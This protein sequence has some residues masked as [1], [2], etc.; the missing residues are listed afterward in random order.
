MYLASAIGPRSAWPELSP[1]MAR[2]RGGV[3]RPTQVYLVCSARARVGKTLLARLIVEYCRADAQP[4]T[5]YTIDPI[6]VALNDFL[7][8]VATTISLTETREQ[9]KLFDRLVIDDATTKIVDIGHQ[10]VDK[11]FTI[12]YDI[13][14]AAE[15][16]G[17]GIDVLVAYLADPSDLSQ[18]TYMALRARFPE[19]S[20]VPVF[21]DAIARGLDFRNMFPASSG[22]IHALTIPQMSPGVHVIADQHPFSF[23]DFLRRPPVNAPRSLLDDIEG[24]VKR[25]HRQL[26]ETELSLLL[27]R[28]RHSLA[29]APV[30]SHFF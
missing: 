4:V 17:R 25:V 10:A 29:A 7:P 8:G 22:G 21:N 3:S 27:N 23:T 6:D 20:F 26:R 11:F 30:Q 12:A 16:H 18:R 28:L 14:F 13:E 19:F 15:A 1:H 2:R 9:M 5:A 24:F